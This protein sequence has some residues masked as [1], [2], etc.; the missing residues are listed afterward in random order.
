MELLVVGQPSVNARTAAT[1]TGL[2][3][4]TK[5]SCRNDCKALVS[6]FWGIGFLLAFAS[7]PILAADLPGHCC[8]LE[9]VQDLA[10]SL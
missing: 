8:L 9:V 2:P 7:D 5:P 1:A 6:V 10:I 4:E 3:H